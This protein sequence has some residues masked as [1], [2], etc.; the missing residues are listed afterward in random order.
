MSLEE[1]VKR[2]ADALEKLAGYQERSLAILEGIEQRKAKPEVVMVPV[3]TPQPAT[4]EVKTV[5]LEKSPKDMSRDE[6][7]AE[8]TRRGVA[9]NDRARQDTLLELLLVE[10]G[11]ASATPAAPAP[12]A[13]KPSA[14]PSLLDEAPVKDKVVLPSRGE[15]APAAPAA[16]AAKQYTAEEARAL[17]REFAAKFGSA[18]AI[19]ILNK[20]GCPDVTTAEKK[21]IL[22]EFAAEVL[23]QKAEREAASVK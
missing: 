23:K 21:K 15:E 9:Y 14:V 13:P 17:L 5:S 12:A 3:P 11:K 1:N 2:I 19:A 7:K 16:P 6:L 4:P 20:F 10:I 22:N 18:D 8:L